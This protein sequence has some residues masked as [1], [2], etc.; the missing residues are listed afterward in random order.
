MK[1]LFIADH[2]IKLGQKDVPTAWAKMRFVNIW[3]TIK[4]IAHNRGITTIIHGGDIFDSVPSMEELEVYGNMLEELSGFT[5]IIYPGNHEAVKKGTSFMQHLRSLSQAYIIEDYMPEVEVHDMFDIPNSS[6]LPYTDLKKKNWHGGTGKL[7]FTHV[8]GAIM[9]H[10][11]PEI[12]LDLFEGWSTVIA[13][14]LHSHKLSQRNIVYP[15][16]PAS[17]T[18]RRSKSTGGDNGIL[19]IDTITSEWEFVDLGMAQLIKATVTS[20]DEII[21]T[22]PNHTVYDLVG[23]ETSVS[24]VKHKDLVSK[25]ISNVEV[26][27]GSIHLSTGSVQD[28]LAE[29]LK[30]KKGIQDAS[31]YISLMEEIT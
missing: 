25:K 27:D 14:D 6:I 10:V 22:H 11:T 7:L 12:D 23:A 29:Y 1:V 21:P 28:E 3:Q 9:P 16:S 20:E 17:T 30:E 2:H 31:P 13:G 19:I 4:E 8:R 5:N 18:F 15:G 26:E 24:K